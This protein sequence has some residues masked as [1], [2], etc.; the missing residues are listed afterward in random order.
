MRRLNNWRLLCLVSLVSS[1]CAS[2]PESGSISPN[3]ADYNICYLNAKGNAAHCAHK[4]AVSRKKIE[5]I[6]GSVCM[7]PSEL[8]ALLVQLILK[9]KDAE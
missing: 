7:E 9:A 5:A 2:T 3:F 1:G 4:G 8:E 6:D